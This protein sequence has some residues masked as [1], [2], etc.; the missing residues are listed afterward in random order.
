M[1]VPDFQSLMLPG[2][3]AL[4]DGSP[5]PIA[6]VRDRVAASG[7]TYPRICS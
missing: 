6:E 3:V 4:A 1:A 5:T 7:G 2:L